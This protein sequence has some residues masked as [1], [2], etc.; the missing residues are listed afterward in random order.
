MGTT[1]I[2]VSEQTHRKLVLLSREADTPMTD[3]VDQAVEL[4]RRER[5]LREANAQY[6]AL[7]EDEEAWA[8]LQA[9]RT[10]WEGTLDDGLPRE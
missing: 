9:E 5:I 1:T 4:L 2:R 3:L 8:E 6:A 7:R 10:V